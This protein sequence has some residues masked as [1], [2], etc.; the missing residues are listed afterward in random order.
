V[1]PWRTVEHAIAGI[2]PGE[3]V[4]IAGGLYRIPDGLLFGPAGR[5]HA[6]M[7]TFRARS[8]ERVLFTSATGEPPHGVNFRDYVRLDGLWFGGARTPDVGSEC[9]MENSEIGQAFFVGNTDSEIAR[10][11]QLVGCTI[12]G[13]TG[14]MLGTS[15]DMLFEGNRFVL[16]GRNCY[17]HGIYLSGGADNPDQRAA[18]ECSQH[19]ILD[20]NI[21][22]AGEGYAL[23]GYHRPFS[24]ILTRNIVAAFYWGFVWD[25]TDALVANNL[26]W[27]QTGFG[28]RD[29]L[30]AQLYGGHSRV[31]FENNVLGPSSPLVGAEATDAI[32]ANAFLE[33]AA[34]GAGA[35]TLAPGSEPEQ[36]GFAAADFDAAVAALRAAFARPVEEIQ[37]DAAIEPLFAR[38]RAAV[39]EG[40]PL[41]AAG[42]RW[43]P[44]APAIDIGPASP[45]PE[46]LEDWWAAFRAADLRDVDRFGR[47]PDGTE[48]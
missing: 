5:D 11:K 4:V 27:K 21:L 15:E 36:L 38:L 19:M 44:G 22:V 40:S 25:G 31:V 20:S 17:S 8:G 45:A 43:F 16:D 30:G 1:A 33:V 24:G 13:Y 3:T 35:I 9:S 46:C 28:G 34:V 26:F 23:H 48:P 41:R 7:T 29:P 32:R 47:L 14:L 18:G 12:F 42:V 2:A 39:P 37:A 6:T 10:G